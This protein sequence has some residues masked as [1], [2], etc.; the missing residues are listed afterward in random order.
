[1]LFRMSEHAR[2]NIV[3]I[4]LPAAEVTLTWDESQQLTQR[5]D[6][7]GTR[8]VTEVL[9]AVGVSR[10]AMLASLQDTEAIAA[11]CDQWEAEVGE[12]ALPDGIRKLATA[13]R[14][15]LV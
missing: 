3:R 1:M 4:R 12:S 5:A 9:S 8:R 13:A 11:V 14:A 7:P 15:E 2:L 6:Q 10:P